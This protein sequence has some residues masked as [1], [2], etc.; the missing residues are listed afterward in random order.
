MAGRPDVELLVLERSKRVGGNLRTDA[1]DGYLCEQGPNGFLDNAPATLAL[2]DRLGLR[3]RL[4][5]S[6]ALSRRRFVFR[7]GRLHPLPGSPGAFLRSG[8][9]SACGKARVALEPFAARRQDVDETI[10]AFAARRIGRE[11]ADVLIDSMVSGIFAGDARQLSL[12][13]AVP[14][15]WELETKYGGLFRALIALRRKRRTGEPMGAPTGTLT[16]FAGGIEELPRAFEARLGAAVRTDHRVTSILRGAAS[17]ADPYI[18]GVDGLGPVSADAV[19]LAGPARD[20]AA[21]LADMDPRLSAAL[22]A[23]PSAPLAVVCLGYDEHAAARARGPLDGFGF[24]VPRGE[25]PRI[26][27]ALWDSSIYPGRAPAGR[28]LIRAM[29]GGALDGEAVAL[30]DDELVAVVRR[31]LARTMALELEPAFVRI[32]RHPLGIP[33]YTVGHLH[34]LARI[35]ELLAGHAGLFVAGNAY[36]GV[37]MNA[38]IAEAAP[39]ADR[40]VRHVTGD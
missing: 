14:R 31:D 24:L 37:S 33:Q 25:G 9:I 5:A 26:L 34:R 38:C 11:A 23:I 40:I 32:H 7:R 17:G 20:A 22:N 6:S 35:D 29:I 19:V 3:P 18:L 36:R 15:M 16:S 27:G 28:I 8:L 4:L 12:R 21:I 2:V 30:S 10:H 13:A 39:L 1:V